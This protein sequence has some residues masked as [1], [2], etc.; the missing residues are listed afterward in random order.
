MAQLC[1]A[2]GEALK[3]LRRNRELETIGLLHD[4]G[5][6]TID[7]SILNKEDV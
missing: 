7:D 6:I 1:M 3:C 5:K 4:I 2:M